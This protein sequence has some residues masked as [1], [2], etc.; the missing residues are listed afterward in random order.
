MGMIDAASTIA[1]RAQQHRLERR[2]A[3]V[4]R[5]PRVSAW[6]LFKIYKYILMIYR[7]F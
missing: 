3:Y 2:L 5:G 1:A 4:A 7:V 6:T